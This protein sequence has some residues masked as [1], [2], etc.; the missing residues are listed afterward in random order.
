MALPLKDRPI[1]FRLSSEMYHGV[2]ESI[3]EASVCW[4]PDTGSAVFNSEHASDVA[5]RLCFK[6][7]DEIEK[8]RADA[9]K[10]AAEIASCEVAHDL[11][12]GVVETGHEKNCSCKIG[13][14]SMQIRNA[15]LERAKE[16]ECPTPKP[17]P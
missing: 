4:K 5:V 7:A 14:I 11:D 15:I 2:F 16:I 3:G 8:V 6:I 1:C 13:E 10:E 17:K 12:C 9:L